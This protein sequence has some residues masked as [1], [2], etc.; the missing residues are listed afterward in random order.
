MARSFDPDSFMKRRP[1]LQVVWFA[2]VGVVA[3]TAGV[4]GGFHPGERGYV[5]GGIVAILIGVGSL[6]AAYY[7]YLRWRIAVNEQRAA[8]ERPHGGG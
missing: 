7:C 8:D 2:F 4:V 3:L 1:V 6:M 5:V